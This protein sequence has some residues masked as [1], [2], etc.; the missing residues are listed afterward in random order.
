MCV[1]DDDAMVRT[2]LQMLLEVL[3]MR[4]STY[5]DA[6]AFLADPSALGCDVLLLDVRMPGMSGLQLQAQLNERH[7]DVPI[8]FISGHGDIPMAVRAM[9]AGALDFLQKPFNE[10]VLIDWIQ[11]AIQRRESAR[12]RADGADE[13][14]RRLASLTPREREVLD[15]VMEGKAN[16]VIAVDFGVSLK[17]VEQHRS[18][19]MSK[20]GVRKVADIFRLLQGADPPDA[21]GALLG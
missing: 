10:Q 20:L 9:R 6:A 11:T 7:A 4:V 1:V 8:L 2:S 21:G 5:A 19:M 12:D 14:R 18:R 17:T 3:G 16:K 15:A 13:V